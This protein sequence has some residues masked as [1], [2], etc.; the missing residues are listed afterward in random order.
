MSSYALLV[1]Y[2]CDGKPPFAEKQK[3]SFNLVCFYP[4]LA[5]SLLHFFIIHLNEKKKE[6]KLL[7]LNG[8]SGRIGV[9]N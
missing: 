6:K 3:K 9:K 5:L 8:T 4:F 2:L 7:R 1:Y